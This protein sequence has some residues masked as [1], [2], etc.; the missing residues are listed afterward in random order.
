MDTDTGRRL[1]AMREVRVGRAQAAELL[2]VPPDRLAAGADRLGVPGVLGPAELLTLSLLLPDELP[3]PQLWPR[4]LDVVRTWLAAAPLL[5]DRTL[6]VSHDHIT[7]ESD[8]LAIAVGVRSHV[9][10]AFALR[11]AAAWLAGRLAHER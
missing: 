9:A 5:E 4:A 3:A 10:V 1:A 6:V 11:E 2:G 7:V 8:P